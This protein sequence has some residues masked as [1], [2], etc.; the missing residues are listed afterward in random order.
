MGVAAARVSGAGSS[1]HVRREHCLRRRSRCFRGAPL[2]AGAVGHTPKEH[3]RLQ[4][5]SVAGLATADAPLFAQGTEHGVLRRPLRQR[6]A[7][8]AVAAAHAPDVVVVVVKQQRTPCNGSGGGGHT[9]GGFWTGVDVEARLSDRVGVLKR[10]KRSMQTP[11]HSDDARGHA[12][13]ARPR[14]PVVRSIRDKQTGL[15]RRAPRAP[16]SSTAPFAHPALI[17]APQQRA[18]AHKE[19]AVE[20]AAALT[21]GGDVERPSRSRRH[22]VPQRH[23]LR[24]ERAEAAPHAVGRH[25]RDGRGEGECKRR[26]C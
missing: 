10:R 23:V 8:R 1:N 26:A 11:E 3:N 9:S 4:Q 19:Q 14:R 22:L 16:S 21:R 15:A 2:S 24:H 25:V 12:R 13:D 18:L 17:H 6:P 7:P 20:V 5:A